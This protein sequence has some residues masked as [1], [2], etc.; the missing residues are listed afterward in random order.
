MDSIEVRPARPEDVPFIKDLMIEQFS[1]PV[2]AAHGELIDVTTL[3]GL[4]AWSGDTP[5]GLLTYRADPRPELGWEVVSLGSVVS[6]RGAGSALIEAVKQ[7]AQAAEAKRLWVI[8]TNNNINGLRF[9]QRRGFD[10]VRVHRDAVTRARALKPSM[11]THVDGI[12]MRHEI[13]LEMVLG[14]PV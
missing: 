6:G 7:L 3:P 13:E 12:A 9:Y 8:T 11:P 5:V 4:I 14:D 10:L 2:V 1:A